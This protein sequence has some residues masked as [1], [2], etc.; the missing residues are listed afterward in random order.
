[1]KIEVVKIEEV[2]PYEGNPRSISSAAIEK[3]AKS[4]KSFGFRQ[5]IVVDKDYFVVVGHTRL[6]GAKHLGLKEVPVHV[7][8]SLTDAEVKAYRIADN[9]TGE[10]TNWDDSLLKSELELLKTLEVDLQDTGFSEK[11][12]LKALAPDSDVD[13]SQELDGNDFQNFEHKCPKCGFEY[14]KDA[15]PDGKTED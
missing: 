14:D 1:M 2:K 15:K 10:L 8:D 11:E 12:L 9:K 7:A 6:L 5:P 3:V 4:L 13:G